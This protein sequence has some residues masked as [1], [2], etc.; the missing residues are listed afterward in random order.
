MTICPVCDTESEQSYRCSGCGKD[1]VGTEE[2]EGRE[3]IADGA[4]DYLV[5]ISA[6]HNPE[7]FAQLIDSLEVGDKV[8]WNGRTEPFTVTGVP[9]EESSPD[10]I[11]RFEKRLIVENKERE[12]GAEFRLWFKEGQDG[13]L[14]PFATELDTRCTVQRQ[15]GDRGN[16]NGWGRSTD[17][18]S[19]GHV[20]PVESAERDQPREVATDGGQDV[21]SIWQERLTEARF[22]TAA[23]LAPERLADRYDATTRDEIE[24]LTNEATRVAIGKGYSTLTLED[25]DDA[26]G[27]LEESDPEVM[28]DGGQS[29]GSTEHEQRFAFWLEPDDY[30]R[31][32]SYD[33][34]DIN[35][36]LTEEQAVSLIDK[37]EDGLE[38]IREQK[39]QNTGS[40]PNGGASR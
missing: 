14:S 34:G 25:L 22:E 8:V 18:E 37:L 15:I 10:G 32:N 2:T 11:G 20:N 30:H 19:L 40:D 29:V 7:H 23:D 39:A 31:A 17:I 13:D 5:R 3:P 35:L 38:T 33:D 21:A 12:N 24:Q 26:V 27:R 16:D 1:L 4:Y 36:E 9:L 28:T 6:P